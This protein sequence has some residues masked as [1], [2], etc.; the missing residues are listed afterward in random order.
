MI[1]IDWVSTAILGVAFLL[2]NV[3]AIPLVV[4]NWVFAIA[5]FAV[6]GYRYMRGAAGLNMLFVILAA[7]LGAWYAWRAIKTPRSP[8][9]QGD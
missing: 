4:R 5:C 8:P 7:A 1:G 3:R 2:S 6:A 9:T